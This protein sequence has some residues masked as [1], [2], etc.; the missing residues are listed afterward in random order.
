MRSAGLLLLMTLALAGCG[1]SEP[2]CPSG[3]VYT[4]GPRKGQCAS[5]TAVKH[6][7]AQAK[8][9]GEVQK[10]LSEV[11]AVLRKRRA[12][13]TASAAESLGR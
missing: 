9:A 13:E 4:E 12:E 8:H 3:S 2:E 7:E 5:A 10:E 11:E 1:A 6:S